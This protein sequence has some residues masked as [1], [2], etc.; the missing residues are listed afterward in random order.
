MALEHVAGPGAA[1]GLRVDAVVD[2]HHPLRRDLEVGEDVGAHLLRHRDHP[3]RA[4]HRQ[5]LGP[6]RHGVAGAELIRLPRTQRLEAVERD[7]ERQV[8]DGLHQHPAQAHVPGVGV[9][10]VRR[11]RVAGHREPHRQRL[12]RRRVGGIGP[13]GQTLP[14]GVA[15]HAQGGLGHR[16]VAEAADLDRGASG[17]RAAQMVHHDPRA[18]VDVRRVL[19]A[20]QQNPHRRHPGELTA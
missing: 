14:G 15:A 1:E 3:L 17:Q 4:L 2:H 10:D 16:L 19:P 20:Q 13:A 6:R 8:V 7:H 9:H 5:A 12:E 11:D 18:S